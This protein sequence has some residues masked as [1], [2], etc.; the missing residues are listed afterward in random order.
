[1]LEGYKSIIVGYICGDSANIFQYYITDNRVR[2]TA[3]EI[4][5][6]ILFRGC[7]S[8]TVLTTGY[9]A[10][11]TLINRAAIVIRCIF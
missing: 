5:S 10:G 1:M 7:V 2:P 11:S 8:T 4:N 6:S 9:L 3:I